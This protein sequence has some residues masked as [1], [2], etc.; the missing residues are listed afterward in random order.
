MRGCD[1]GANCYVIF[2]SDRASCLSN[3][4]TSMKAY[5]LLFHKTTIYIKTE[6]GK[7]NPYNNFKYLNSLMFA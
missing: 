2:C 3:C 1:W 4:H 6:L 5:M 7:E